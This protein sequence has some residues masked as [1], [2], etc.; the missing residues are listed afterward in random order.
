LATSFLAQI[1]ALVG[2][3]TAAAQ[4][5]PGC[6]GDRRPSKPAVDNAD[7]EATPRQRQGASHASRAGADDQYLVHGAYNSGLR[8]I[9][10]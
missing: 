10:K 7:G 2:Q 9:R 6:L 8:T 1:D 3:P 5:A 4:V